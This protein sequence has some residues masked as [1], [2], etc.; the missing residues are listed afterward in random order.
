MVLLLFSQLHHGDIILDF[1]A[2]DKGRE[3][4]FPR[5]IWKYKIFTCELTR[6]TLVYIEQDSSDKK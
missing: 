4:N 1:R 2:V 3:Q 6:N 5:K